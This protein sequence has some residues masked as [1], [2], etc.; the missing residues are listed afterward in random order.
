[1]NYDN[2]PNTA[3][4]RLDFLM[5]E[6]QQFR[7]KK[8]YCPAIDKYVWV[9]DHSIKE[10]A[11][12]AKFTKESTRIA[13]Q[14]PAVI[15]NAQQLIDTAAPKSNTQ[16]N[17]MHMNKMFILHSELPD[18]GIAK[19]IIGRTYWGKYIHYSITAIKIYTAHQA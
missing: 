4:K 19:L 12:N 9:N 14:L 16:K 1:M 11:N 17:T 18:L 10:T 6:L 3:S 13:L 15:E 2:I 5:Q 8:F 7:L